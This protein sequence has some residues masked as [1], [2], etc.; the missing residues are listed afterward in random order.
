[1]LCLK[2]RSSKPNNFMYIGTG[3]RVRQQW[4]LK[5]VFWLES[6][7]IAF[8]RKRIAANLTFLHF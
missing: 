7:A 8:E 1:M 4:L 2:E 3:E 6:K 5:N